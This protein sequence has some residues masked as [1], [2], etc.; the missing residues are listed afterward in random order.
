MVIYSEG[1]REA[2]NSLIMEVTSDGI[3]LSG[4]LTTSLTAGIMNEVSFLSSWYNFVAL[5]KLTPFNSI[6]A[7]DLGYLAIGRK[8]INLIFLP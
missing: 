1:L 2:L 5:I 7:L 4:V 8:G 6:G 3:V